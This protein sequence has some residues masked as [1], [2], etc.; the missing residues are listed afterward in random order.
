MPTSEGWSEI[1]DWARSTVP[2]A[3]T[4][5]IQPFAA[6]RIAAIRI[7]ATVR[8]ATIRYGHGPSDR[9]V[10]PSDRVS[11]TGR[12]S[13]VRDRRDRRLLGDNSS[14]GGTLPPVAVVVSDGGAEFVE[15][16]EDVLGV[17]TPFDGMGDL[18]AHRV[19]LRVTTGSE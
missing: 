18:G 4:A 6:A 2:A 19:E 7:G 9:P 1:E 3:S 15:L 16:R 14:G 17:T 11:A 5:G 13:S 12:T 8:V 10:S